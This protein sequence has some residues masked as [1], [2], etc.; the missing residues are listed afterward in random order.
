MS[1]LVGAFGVP[2]TPLL[3][4]LRHDR[5]ATDLVPV[6]Q[7]F[8]LVGEMIADARPDALVMIASDHL[9]QYTVENMPA[10][11]IG[12]APE[13]RGTYPN[14]ERAFGLPPVELAGDPALATSI[15][16]AHTLTTAIDFSFTNRPWLDHAYVVPLL[17]VVPELDIPIVPI[18]T[19]TNAPPIPSA[20]RFAALGRLVRTAIDSGPLNRRVVLLATG[21]LALDLGGPRQFTGTTPDPDFDR[22]AMEW[23]ADGELDAALA[24]STFDRLRQAGNLT[25]QFLDF[26]SLLAAADR[27]PD[28]A[29]GIPCRFGTEPFF[30]WRRP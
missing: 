7:H 29:V 16:G 30:A 11:S 12:K 25:F 24:G 28:L 13:I 23:M 8:R 10:F 17:Q 14:E 5:D 4:R 22:Q 3:W 27:A 19:N 26:V 20:G 1:E 21:H 18:H 2:H 6:F 9:H 15:G